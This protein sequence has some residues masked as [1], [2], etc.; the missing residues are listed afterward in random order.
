M[1]KL[2]TVMILSLVMIFSVLCLP[3][4]ARAATID[5][6][7]IA[8]S[9]TFEGFTAVEALETAISEGLDAFA[10]EIDISGL[11][12]PYTQG[13]MDAIFA[14]IRDYCGE[15]E[16]FHVTS[17]K[18]SVWYYPSS[19]AKL[20]VSYVYSQEEYGLKLQELRTAAAILLQGIEN[21]PDLNDVEKALLLHDRLGV[22]NRYDTKNYYNN[23]VADVS[24]TAYGALVNRISVCDGYAKAYMYL[25]ERVGI[26]SQIIRSDAMN[27]AWNMVY[28]DG[29]PYHVDVTHDD[30]SNME[31]D[32]KHDN[33]LVSTQGYYNSST[34]HQVDDYDSTPA[35]TRYDDY[36]WQDSHTAFQLLDG[37]IYYID[38]LQQQL[39]RWDGETREIL[40]DVSARWDA[41][42]Y[43][44]WPAQY[45]RLAATSTKLLY[46]G[47][48]GVYAYDPVSNTSEK[49]FTPSNLENYNR[50]YGFYYVDGY[51]VCNIAQGPNGIDHGDPDCTVYTTETM[52]YPEETASITGSVSC[53]DSTGDVTVRLYA[54]GDLCYELVT[55]TG[56]YALNVVPGAYV[57]E[58]SMEGCVTRSYSVQVEKDGC[59]Q[60]VTLCKRGDVTGDGKVTAADYVRLALHVKG[61]RPLTD[62]Y[63]LLCADVN[64]NGR[65]TA[66]D[67]S[68]LARKVKGLA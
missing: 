28:I 61:I 66:A 14:I 27:H 63:A 2:R 53:N 30:N 17:D 55:A 12:I 22:W 46:S 9:Y 42:P 20:T 62:A 6:A 39:M 67:Y 38:N 8:D 48:Q 3:A 21:N 54:D 68:L 7:R 34:Q 50:I 64:G 13:N 36:F 10:A 45:A 37:D 26:E 52:Y 4:R 35:D 24:H 33:F 57:L 5:S 41:G 31:G 40:W 1:K 60:D 18:V 51:L 19:V 23:T 58:A 15:A 56:E 29:V 16:N 43:S 47:S 59:I 44:Y 32:I 11:A 65:V 49:I 25:L